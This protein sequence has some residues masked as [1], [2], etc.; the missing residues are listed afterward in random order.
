MV[1]RLCP[2]GPPSR[3]LDAFKLTLAATLEG[4]RRTW[5]LEADVVQIGRSSRCPVHLPDA[6]VS[7]THAEI[8]RAGDGWLIRDLGSR[9]GTRVNGVDAVRA[10]RDPATATCWRSA[11]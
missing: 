3:S 5:P 9:N 6:T 4:Q 10:H 7:K 8:V 2:A 11:R 1:G